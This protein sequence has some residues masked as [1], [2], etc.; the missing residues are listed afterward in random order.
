MN[1]DQLEDQ[2]NSY[3][4]ALD[5]DAKRVNRQLVPRRDLMQKILDMWP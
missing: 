3:N 2:L 5:D 4:Q 1:K